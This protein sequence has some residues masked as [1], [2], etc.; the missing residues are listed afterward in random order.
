MLVVRHNYLFK[1][2]ANE[3]LKVV[4]TALTDRNDTVSASYAT[5]CGYLSRLSSD[6]AVISLLKRCQKLYFEEQGRGDN[7]QLTFEVVC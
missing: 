7:I 5:A 1:P 2:Y 6:K 3:V 4:S